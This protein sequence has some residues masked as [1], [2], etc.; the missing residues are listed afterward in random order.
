MKSLYDFIKESYDNE[1]E[2]INESCMTI[3]FNGM[4]NTEDVLKKLEDVDCVTVNDKEV[5]ISCDNVD[6]VKKAYEILKSYSDKERNSQHRSSDEQY[7]QKT[8]KI[9][10]KVNELAEMIEKLEKPEE[11]EGDKKEEE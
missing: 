8:I 9:E 2:Y 4:D 1:A 6:S 11:P 7:A 5:E 10:N 3:N